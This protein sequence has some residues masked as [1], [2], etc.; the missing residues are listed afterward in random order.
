[1]VYKAS[2]KLQSRHR[3]VSFHDI[4]ARVKEIVA[5]SGLKD[6]NVVVYSPHTPSSVITQE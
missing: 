1:M 3:A 6:G 2:I 5:E 4:T